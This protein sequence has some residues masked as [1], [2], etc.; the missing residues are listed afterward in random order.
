MCPSTDEVG[1]QRAV[2]TQTGNELEGYTTHQTAT[3]QTDDSIDQLSD[4]STPST[5]AIW[6][7]TMVVW[8]STYLKEQPEAVFRYFAD[9]LLQLRQ[10][11]CGTRDF[12]D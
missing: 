1:L 6:G 4:Q 7:P 9:K 8:N 5:I 10:Q 11:A 3:T 12:K 2:A